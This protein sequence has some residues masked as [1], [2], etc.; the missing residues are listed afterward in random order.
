MTIKEMLQLPDDE[1][2]RAYLDLTREL[3]PPKLLLFIQEMVDGRT[4]EEKLKLQELNQRLSKMPEFFEPMKQLH[5]WRQEFWQF[6][7][8]PDGMGLKD[9][10]QERRYQAL[11][12]QDQL[13]AYDG[14]VVVKAD[15]GP[16]LWK[17]HCACAAALAED[18]VDA[19]PA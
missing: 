17:A 9:D 3:E 8:A 10:A 7:G 16:S 5:A 2:D 12:A 11:L 14:R 1:M 18:G 15:V 13:T 19:D 4:P 6:R